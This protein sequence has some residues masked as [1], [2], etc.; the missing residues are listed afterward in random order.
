MLHGGTATQTVR[1]QR[2]P[3]LWRVIPANKAYETVVLLLRKR[4]CLLYVM[5]HLHAV[6]LSIKTWEYLAIN[7]TLLAMLWEGS[8]KR[9]YRIFF[10]QWASHC[11][12]NAHFM[13]WHSLNF[14]GMHLR[15]AS[16]QPVQTS[17]QQI[18]EFAS[19]GKQLSHGGSREDLQNENMHLAPWTAVLLAQTISF[20]LSLITM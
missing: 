15:R 5:Y 17:L 1:I 18:L 6:P 20:C 8:S 4:A 3:L 9:G 7:A 19:P 11:E 16:F 2:Q 13:S 10:L 12:S 14:M